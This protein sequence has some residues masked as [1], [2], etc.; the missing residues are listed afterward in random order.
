MNFY[1]TRV[2]VVEVGDTIWH[3]NKGIL[4]RERKKY[5]GKRYLGNRYLSD[6]FSS[7]AKV[8]NIKKYSTSTHWDARVR[9]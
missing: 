4:W 3:V 2:A 5:G 8:V 7:K 6:Y 9:I 1:Y